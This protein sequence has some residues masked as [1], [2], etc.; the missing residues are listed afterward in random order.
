MD[1]TEASFLAD[2]YTFSKLPWTERVRDATLRARE[3]L[4]PDGGRRMRVCGR[5]RSTVG[6]LQTSRRG[7]SGWTLR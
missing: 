6:K 7:G 2:L 3:N 5:S 4:S 1:R